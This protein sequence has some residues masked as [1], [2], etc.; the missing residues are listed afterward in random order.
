VSAGTQEEFEMRRAYVGALLLALVA[1][2]ALAQ[3]MASSGS[4]PDAGP[5]A[6]GLMMSYGMVKGY[7]TKAADQ[8]PDKLYTFKATPEVRSLGQLFAHVAD[9]NY[10]ICGAAAGDKAPADSVEKTKTAK[11]DIVKALA[12]SFAYCDKIYGGLS[13]AD[14]S[15]EINLFGMKGTKLGV[16]SFN[17]AHD[18]EHYGNIVTYMRLNK[19][20]PPSSQGGGM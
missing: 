6:S 10:M 16:L 13:E 15:T 17:T 5:L 11:A 19:M 20:V 18:F 1:A 4:T 7:I 14:A 9:A 8:V 3:P 12:D 2:P